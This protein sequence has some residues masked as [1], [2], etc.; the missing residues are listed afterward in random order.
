MVHRINFDGSS[1]PGITPD[2]LR[3]CLLYLYQTG[4]Q[5]VS[6]EDLFSALNNQTQLPEKAAV[7]TMDDGYIDQALIAAPIFIEL[8]CPV[9][10]FVITDMID[11]TM[12]PWD[13]QV[14]WIINHTKKHHWK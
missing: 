1:K 14:S 11:Q 6:L 9:T 4:Y 3:N 7:F 5:P 2:H 13:A 12:W 10:F 8:D